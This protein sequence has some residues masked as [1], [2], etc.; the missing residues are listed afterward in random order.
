MLSFSHMAYIIHMFL[1]V[2]FVSVFHPTYLQH[3]LTN[4]HYLA[5]VHFVEVYSSAGSSMQITNFGLCSLPQA[6]I[7]MRNSLPCSIL[8]VFERVLPA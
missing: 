7:W 6:L 8:V 1:N 3:G 4:T 5:G 2:N